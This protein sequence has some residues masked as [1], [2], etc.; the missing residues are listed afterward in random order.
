M[1]MTDIERLENSKS[2]LKEKLQ[3][4]LKTCKFD[5]LKPLLRETYRNEIKAFDCAISALKRAKQQESEIKKL[6]AE[7]ASLQKA[8]AT[9]TLELDKVYTTLDKRIEDL[10]RHMES[11][12]ASLGKVS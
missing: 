12:V 11:I 2:F 6:R 7:N 8:L 3:D 10:E 4:D 5:E 1:S 9:K